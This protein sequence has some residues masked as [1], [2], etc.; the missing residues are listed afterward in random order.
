MV[1]GIILILAG[2]VIAIYPPLL[3]LIVALI[4]IF[5]GI[6]FIYLSFY[7]KKIS[8]KFEDPFIDFFFRI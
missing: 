4:L 3:S 5:T 1:L 7:Y 8:K 2:I 6:I